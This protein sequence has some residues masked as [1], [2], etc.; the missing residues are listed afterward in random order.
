MKTKIDSNS[1]TK[2]KLRE[3]RKKLVVVDKGKENDNH[4]NCPKK[5]WMGEKKDKKKGKKGYLHNRLNF[6]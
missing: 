3:K 4:R 1:I 5:K 6:L 2:E